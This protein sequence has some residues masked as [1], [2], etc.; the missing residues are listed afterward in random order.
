LVNNPDY[1]K[2]L[3]MDVIAKTI[4]PE[5]PKDSPKASVIIVTYN[6]DEKEFRECLEPLMRQTRQDFE[7]L[8]L[9]NSDKNDAKHLLCELNLTYIKLRKNYGLSLARNVGIRLSKGEFVI[10]LDD[11]ARVPENWVEEHLK[12]HE[13]HDIIGLRGKCLP[14]HPGFFNDLST[15]YDMGDEIIP[16]H[17]DLEGNSSFRKQYLFEIGGYNPAFAKS[18]GAEGLELAYRLVSRYKDRNKLIYYPG[19]VIYH[20]S[21]SGYLEYMRKRKRSI[22]HAAIAKQIFPDVF[23]FARSYPPPIL[24]NTSLA[25]RIKLKLLKLSFPIYDFLYA[26]ALVLGRGERERTSD[27]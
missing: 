1:I 26:A 22:K 23:E 11:D 25:F 10:F 9:D 7:I 5:Y 18:G 20:D 6:P 3:D 12:A 14:K 8:L 16:S 4:Q 27:W 2:Q 19:A 21:V 15:S 24:R 13:T 17:M